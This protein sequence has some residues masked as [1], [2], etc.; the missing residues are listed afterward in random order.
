MDK[1]P[2]APE[3]IYLI[4]DASEG[5]LGYVW[6]DDPAPGIGMD[7]AD[8]IEYRRADVA[9]TALAAAEAELKEWRDMGTRAVT[10]GRDSGL[11]LPLANEIWP[12]EWRQDV[13]IV[14]YLIHRHEARI[15]ELLAREQKQAEQ[16]KKQGLILDY[17]MR[18]LRHSAE[19]PDDGRMQAVR[20]LAKHS[21]RQAGRILAL[22]KALEPFAR[23]EVSGM[24]KDAW[25]LQFSDPEGFVDFTDFTIGDL[26]RAAA[27]LKEK[28]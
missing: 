24:Y 4:P 15:A 14:A 18:G 28:E 25:H 21:E 12:N 10:G 2:E 1:L 9:D 23:E 16:R 26:R 7:P 5:V 20:A 3:T 22:E 19:H 8:A 13:A 27:L 11:E 17:A 6:C